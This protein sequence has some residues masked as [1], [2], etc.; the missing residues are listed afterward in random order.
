MSVL[1]A[2]RALV[3]IDTYSVMRDPMLRWICIVAPLLGLLLR[4]AAPPAAAALD[5]RFGL[6]LIPYYGLIMSFLPIAVAA[7]VGTVTGF[8]LLDQRDDQTITALLVTPLSLTRYLAYR[9]LVQML[10]CVVLSCVALALAGL[11]ATTPLQ[12][13]VSSVSAAPL[14]PIYA[15]F[16]GSF[17]NNKVQGFALIK[18]LGI[19]IVPCVAAYFVAQPWQSAFGLVPHY[20]PLKVYWLFDR[21]APWPAAAHAMG[22][23]IVHTMFFAALS[24]RFAAVLRR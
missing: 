15:I 24:R 21:G 16:L 8:L 7:M 22:G 20:W 9:L 3:A 19:I 6:D 4:Y 1:P 18:A 23:L 13:L 12:V 11:S 17:A 10:L 5:H 2:Y 14:A